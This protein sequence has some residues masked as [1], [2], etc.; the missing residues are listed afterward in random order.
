MKNNND[1]NGSSSLAAERTSGVGADPG[2]SRVNLQRTAVKNLRETSSHLRKRRKLT[3]SPHP[4]RIRTSESEQVCVCVC[5]E[6]LHG[7]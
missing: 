1:K 7:L 5:V 6:D 3:E 2:G 4:Q